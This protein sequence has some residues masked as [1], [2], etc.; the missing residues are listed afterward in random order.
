MYNDVLK[1]LVIVPPLVSWSI[2]TQESWQMSHN[3]HYYLKISQNLTVYLRAC[4]SVSSMI[5]RPS[6]LP[7]RS[8]R[9]TTERQN[10]SFTRTLVSQGRYSDQNL[11]PVLGHN[12]NCKE[13][14]VQVK[15]HMTFWFNIPNKILTLI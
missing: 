8:F 14:S 9:I 2:F 10:A 3:N 11:R 5:F 4:S 6:P 13:T 15:T 7:R 12:T 1:T